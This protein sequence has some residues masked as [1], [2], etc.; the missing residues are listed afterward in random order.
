MTGAALAVLRVEERRFH[1][2][3]LDPAVGRFRP[4]EAE[5]ALRIEGE[6]GVTLTRAPPGSRAD[7]VDGAG[8]TYDAVGNFPR[9]YFYRQWPHLR[10]QIERHLTK[11]DLVPV[12]VSQFTAQQVTLVE[13]FIA[14]RG[15]GPRVFMVGQ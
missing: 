8:T 7:W 12:D 10:Y 5:T 11:A 13:Q 2:L 4:S 9:R 14:D 3:G 1:D 6:L 15:L